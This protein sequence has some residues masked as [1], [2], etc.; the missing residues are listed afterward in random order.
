MT[1]VL[2]VVFLLT[3]LMGVPIAFVI[4][5][6]SLIALLI[7]GT[8]PLNALPQYLFI[9]LDS[10]P[11]L[12]I[13]FFV[14]AGELMSKTGISQKLIDFTMVL[15]GRMPGAL[16]EVNIGTS[17]FFAGITGA[18]VA[19]TA[20]VGGV[21]I[22]AMKKEGYSAEYSAAVTAASSCIGPI[23]P[24]SII[25]VVFGIAT[26]TSI[27]SL[28][29]AGIIPGILMGVSMGVVAWFQA[30]KHRFPCRTERFSALELVKA[31]I[32]AV[33]ALLMPLIIVGGIMG[34][35]F[36]ATESACIAVLYSLFFGLLTRRL[37]LRDLPGVCIRTASISGVVLLIIS[38][39]KL[40]SILMVMNQIPAKLTALLLSVSSSKVSILLMINLLLLITGCF[41]E[42]S[43]ACIILAPMLMPVVQNLGLH[44][45]H[46][47]IIMCVNLAIGLATPPVGP[48]LFVA[49]RIAGTSMERITASIWP[50]LLAAIASLLL[51]TFIPALSM[52]VPSIF[53]L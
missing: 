20:A 46:F 49:C 19:D 17:I 41:M 47:G 36:T 39:A 1:I 14:L 45:V 18:A 16:A 31:F 42:I 15:F 9:G 10:F 29:L 34:G 40:F 4:G 25:L 8:I 21:L 50:F 43:A 51:L 37:K 35:V 3:L 6:T 48:T 32:K 24:P 5:I 11:L 38:T 44:P 30:V 28:L 7:Q 52:I 53:I 27:A 2:P 12:A 22:P 13:P 23:V 26:N 33:P